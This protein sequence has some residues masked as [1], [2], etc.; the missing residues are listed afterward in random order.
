MN[1]GSG[2][3]RDADGRLWLRFSDAPARSWRQAEWRACGYA[4][5]YR[6][7]SPGDTPLTGWYLYGPDG[8]PFGEYLSRRLAT[9]LDVAADWI[10]SGPVLIPGDPAPRDADKDGD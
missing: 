9:A 6:I 5:Q 7:E 8:Y 1:S 4:V 10:T 3:R 2:E